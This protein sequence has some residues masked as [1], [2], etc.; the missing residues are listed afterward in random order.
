MPVANRLLCLLAEQYCAIEFSLLR[1][2]LTLPE[3]PELE[4]LPAQPRWNREDDD[5][6]NRDYFDNEQELAGSD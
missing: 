2:N 1:L 4:E 5:F 3:V 6:D